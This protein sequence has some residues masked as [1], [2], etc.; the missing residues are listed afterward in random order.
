M[1]A[2]NFSTHTEERQTSKRPFVLQTYISITSRSKKCGIIGTRKN[3]SI[4]R[5]KGLIPVIQTEFRKGKKTGI[6][7][8]RMYTHSYTRSIRST[9]PEPT[10]MVFF[11]AKKA[12]DSVWH[13]GLLHKAM[14]DGLP[15]IIIR[16]LRTWLQDRTMRIRIGTTLSRQIKI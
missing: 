2:G 10:I 4:L 8:K 6:N 9:H 15:G 5:Q 3:K 7:L 11:D 14:R 13:T 1:E 16:F 12:F